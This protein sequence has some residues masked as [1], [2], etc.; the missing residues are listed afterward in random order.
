MESGMTM[1]KILFVCHGNICRSPMAEFIMKKAVA[2]AG[3]SG[4][5]EIASAATSTEEIGNDIYPPAKETLRRHGIPFERRRARRITPEDYRH[6]D[7]IYVMDRNNLRW[8]ERLMP[9]PDG[10]ARLLM[11]VVG[12]G[13]DVA[14]PWYTGDFE[15][16]YLDIS[17]AAEA[18]L[19]DNR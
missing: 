15:A 3:L 16:T 13:R 10:K 17:E 9:D 8:L 18:L 12:E 11:S 6:Y 5:Y 19:N 14:D 2:D 1:K 7:R 4:E